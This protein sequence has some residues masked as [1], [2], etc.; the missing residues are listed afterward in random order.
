MI[1]KHLDK[2]DLILSSDTFGDE[3]IKYPNAINPKK[4]PIT[5]LV[6][7]ALEPTQNA[8]LRKTNNSSDKLIYPLIKIKNTN[9]AR[10]FLVIFIHPCLLMKMLVEIKLQCNQ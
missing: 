9:H 3:P 1:M 8:I 5:M 7:T 4:V 6:I 2:T 10:D